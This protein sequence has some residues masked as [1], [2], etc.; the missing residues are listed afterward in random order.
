MEGSVIEKV[1]LNLNLPNNSEKQ[2]KVSV[3]LLLTQ[4]Q[5]D[6]N[7]NYKLKYWVQVVVQD[8][9]SITKSN[10]TNSNTASI[11]EW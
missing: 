8:C 1:R 9:T 5:V 10:T 7:L 11:T 3:F 4:F 6:F 2:E